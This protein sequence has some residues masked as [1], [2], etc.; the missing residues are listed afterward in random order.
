MRSKD[1][2]GVN[3]LL[4]SQRATGVMKLDGLETLDE[5]CED[6]MPRFSASASAH[7]RARLFIAA[8]FALSSHGARALELPTTV[9]LAEENSTLKFTIGGLAFTLSV[10]ND[11]VQLPRTLEWT[12]DGRRILVYPSGP[13][14]LLDVGHL[15]DDS[16]VGASQMHVQGPMLG[17]GPR[18]GRG[19][20][21]PRRCARA[22]AS[23]GL[24]A[25]RDQLRSTSS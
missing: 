4:L 6:H 11:P 18:R 15:H 8:A 10:P 14:T 2:R 17:Y 12:V 20:A 19:P 24:R 16:H 21:R 3:E 25:T 1:A 13:S 5:G 9:E 22:V 7:L 23:F